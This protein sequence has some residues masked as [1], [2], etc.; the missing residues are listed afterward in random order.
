MSNEYKKNSI[1]ERTFSLLP[2]A[3]QRPRYDVII[4]EYSDVNRGKMERAMKLIGK[5]TET[6]VTFVKW[7]QILRYL[8]EIPIQILK[9]YEEI[10][11]KYVMILFS[12]TFSSNYKASRPTYEYKL[13]VWDV[14]QYNQLI[15]QVHF[16]IHNYVLLL[17]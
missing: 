15:N 10:Y 13:L 11:R 12:C 1:Y 6:L 16:E 14:K 5:H 3:C 8:L 4:L 7:S 2:K 17:Y 9:F